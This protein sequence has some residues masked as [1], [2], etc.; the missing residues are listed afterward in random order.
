MLLLM[1][2]NRSRSSST[3]AT[4][5]GFPR[6]RAAASVSQRS[7]WVRSATPGLR[8]PIPGG[9]WT[10]PV[11]VVLDTG[12]DERGHRT[13]WSGPDVEPQPVGHDP[14]TGTVDEIDPHPTAAGGGAFT[15][16]AA[17]PGDD[18]WQG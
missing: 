5:P 8:T 11:P 4:V 2:L 3:T 17:C 1:A 16:G 18:P 15:I 10:A 7:N 6:P 9:R 14:L 13:L 12:L